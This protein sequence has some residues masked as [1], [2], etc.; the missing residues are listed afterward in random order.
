M[1]HEKGFFTKLKIIVILMMLFLIAYTVVIVLEN[2]KI[3]VLKGY[4]YSMAANENSL[5]S[6]E[7]DKINSSETTSNGVSLNKNDDTK[8][9]VSF[10]ESRKVYIMIIGV[11]FVIIIIVLI[12][13]LLRLH[14]SEKNT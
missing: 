8:E 11:C 3:N 2:G 4:S 1:M 10:L 6:T 7:I 9:V 5:D 13:I 12:I 14:Y